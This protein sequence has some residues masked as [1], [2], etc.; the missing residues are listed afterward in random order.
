MLHGT[1]DRGRFCRS[2]YGNGSR[3]LGK[4]YWL[5]CFLRGEVS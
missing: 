5:N 1:G 2:N 4:N 3:R